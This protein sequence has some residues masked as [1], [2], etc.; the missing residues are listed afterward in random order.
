[1]AQLIEHFVAAVMDAAIRNWGSAISTGEHDTPSQRWL[2]Q[3][4]N[5]QRRLN[6]PPQQAFQFYQQ[7]QSWTEQL[8]YTAETTFR[9]CLQLEEPQVHDGVT[10]LWR[11]R[12]LL[13]ARDNPEWTISAREVWQAQS[14]SLRIGNRRVDQPQER[15]RAGLNAA[16]RL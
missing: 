10:S 3:L 11:L 6:L 14:G 2:S 12:F 8:Q 7:W 15:L 16:G 9:V 1:A 5:G 4:L 13:Q